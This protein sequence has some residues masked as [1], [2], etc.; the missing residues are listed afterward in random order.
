MV[1]A[2]G[3]D[4]TVGVG[5]GEADA[6]GVGGGV[7]MGMLVGMDGAEGFNSAKKGMKVKLPKFWANV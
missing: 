7:G 2:V 1:V 4:V 5:V 3:V 6:R